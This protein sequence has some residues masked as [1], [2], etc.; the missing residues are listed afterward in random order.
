MR[1]EHVGPNV[2][3]SSNVQSSNHSR[4][5]R[6]PHMPAYSRTDSKSRLLK[7]MVNLRQSD[8]GSRLNARGAKAR[9]PAN[10]WILN[11]LAGCSWW[12]F[13]HKLM[14]KIVRVLLAERI[15]T[16]RHHGAVDVVL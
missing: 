4:P 16:E 10:T 5:D 1:V 12:V 9:F 2:D 7:T 8:V 3:L 14:A 13:T 6:P 15:Q 11:A